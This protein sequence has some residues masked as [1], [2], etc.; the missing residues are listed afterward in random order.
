MF[1]KLGDLR[2]NESEGRPIVVIVVRCQICMSLYHDNVWE[3]IDVILPWVNP[4]TRRLLSH[5]RIM[6][7]TET[8]LSTDTAYS[9]PVN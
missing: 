2:T 3:P 1:G 5:R 8:G 6:Q 9:E 7:I 4:I